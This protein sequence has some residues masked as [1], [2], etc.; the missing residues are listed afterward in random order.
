[1]I[2]IFFPINI[3]W[4]EEISHEIILKLSIK[5]YSNIN[6]RFISCRTNCS[7][8]QYRH[9][10]CLNIDQCL[11][12]NAL[13]DNPVICNSSDESHQSDSGYNSVDSINFEL[14]P[15]LEEN[16]LPITYGKFTRYNLL[17]D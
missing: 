12:E 4:L 14:N 8:K 17:T 15:Y 2:E 7:L 1:M 11:A 9:K 10:N 13:L 16:M 3:D 6:K 5:N